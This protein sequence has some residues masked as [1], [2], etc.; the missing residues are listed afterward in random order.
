MSPRSS[1]LFPGLTFSAPL[2]KP[3]TGIK[4]KLNINPA[5]DSKSGL[6]FYYPNQL[7]FA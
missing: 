3:A 5:K 1:N 6:N 7:N 4:V 2:P